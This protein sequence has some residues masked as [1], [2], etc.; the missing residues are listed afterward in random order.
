MHRTSR[1]KT[2]RHANDDQHQ[3]KYQRRADKAKLARLTENRRSEEI[4][5]NRLSSI[6]GGG[7]SGKLEGLSR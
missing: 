6:S 2:R 7:G 5:L 3:R 4:R 1:E